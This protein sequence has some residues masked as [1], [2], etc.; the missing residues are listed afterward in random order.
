MT[1]QR[2]PLKVPPG[3]VRGG[4]PLASQGR[5]YDSHLVRWRDGVMQPVGGWEAKSAGVDAEPI[6]AYSWVGR[7]GE[8]WSAFG[9]GTRLYMFTDPGV[10]SR[11]TAGSFTGVIFGGTDHRH[12]ESLSLDNWGGDLVGRIPGTGTPFTVDTSAASPTSKALTAPPAAGVVATPERYL[13]V[14]GLQG[15]PNRVHWSAQADLSVWDATDPESGSGFLDVGIKGEMLAAKR[16]RGETLIWTTAELL[17][18]RWISL[19][20]IYRVDIVGEASCVSRRGMVVQGSAAYWMGRRNF[21]TY[22]GQVQRL[23]CPVADY[24]FGGINQA[25]AHR[26]WCETHDEFGE[27]TWH[28]PSGA[29]TTPDRYVTYN[30]EMGIWYF[31]ALSRAAGFG[32]GVFASAYAVGS[33]GTIYEHETG[34]SYDGVGL[35]YAVTGALDVTEGQQTM[36]IDQIYPDRG[37]EGDLQFELLASDSPRGPFDSVGKWTA[38]DRVDTRI[39]A[40]H[41]QIRVEQPTD[42]EADP[43]MTPPVVG[44][45]FGGWRYGVPR[46]RMQPAGWR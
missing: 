41:V 2:V 21:W 33:D 13:V 29:S 38:S 11:V 32:S 20:Y 43:N 6:D 14:F 39:L 5:W 18:M 19:P 34:S 37:T 9:T 17:S 7:S 27:I 26:V 45:T 25:A 36:M 15:A 12:G 40:R 30:Y 1:W 10:S 3:V 4:S 28:Y 22:T 35:P 46:I 31:G 24:V 42:I 23:A 44:K 8:P 16:A